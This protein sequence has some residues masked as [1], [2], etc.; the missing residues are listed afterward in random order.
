MRGAETG[1]TGNT[2]FWFFARKQIG[3]TY[4]SGRLG[5]ETIN[6]LVTHRYALF[7][8]GYVQSGIYE[9]RRDDVAYVSVSGQGD[10][11][12]VS[13]VG[14][15][16]N[17]TPYNAW[18]TGNFAATS[19]YWYDS[20]NGYLQSNFGYKQWIDYPCS[21]YPA[22]QCFN[23]E[24]DRVAAIRGLVRRESHVAQLLSDGL[25]DMRGVHFGVIFGSFAS[26]IDDIDSDIDV[27]VVGEV[28]WDRLTKVGDAV[29][30]HVRREVNFV[31]W[32]EDEFRQPK[33]GQRRLLES[34]LRR[35]RILV[36][37]SE[38]EFIARA[39][40]MAGEVRDRRH[41]GR[42]RPESGAAVRVPR[43]ACTSEGPGSCYREVSTTSR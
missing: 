11:S 29:S 17:L 37:G 15:A 32:S 5:N 30:D 42:K 36:K 20:P 38:H 28:N 12:C 4:Q 2:Y 6:T 1:G 40:G 19:T 7:Y 43:R 26:G 33:T 14:V 31:V 13:S 34:I 41:T 39:R 16:S 23:P 27:L 9:V 22:S 21:Q 25:A 3:G 8:T 24:S 35:P 10:G 18:W